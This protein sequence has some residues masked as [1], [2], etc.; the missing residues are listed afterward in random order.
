MVVILDSC[1]LSSPELQNNL[2]VSTDI[3]DFAISL[4]HIHF[5]FLLIVKPRAKFFGL[6]S[7]KVLDYARNCCRRLNV[8]YNTFRDKSQ[9]VKSQMVSFINSQPT[10]RLSVPRISG[11][12]LN[13]ACDNSTLHLLGRMNKVKFIRANTLILKNLIAS[14]SKIYTV[15]AQGGTGPL[16]FS[17]QDETFVTLK[18]PGPNSADVLQFVCFVADSS[19]TKPNQIFQ[20]F[21]IS[22]IDINDN[23]PIFEDYTIEIEENF[24]PPDKLLFTL[25]A[26]DNEDKNDAKLY[27]SIF[28]GKTEVT[29]TGPI[30]KLY[31]KE[32][33]DFEQNVMYRL[34]VTAFDNNRNSPSLNATAT[35][36]INVKD[37]DDEG[38]VFTKQPSFTKLDE[39]TAVGTFVFK[40]KAEDGDRNVKDPITYIITNGSYEISIFDRI[41]NQ[42]GLFRIDASTGE[43]FVAKTFDRETMSNAEIILEITAKE[44]NKGAGRTKSIDCTILIQDVNDEAPTFE[45]DEYVGTITENSF[46][47]TAVQLAGYNNI[48]VSD[49][50]Q[51]QNAAFEVTVITHTDLFHLMP[52]DGIN[53]AYLSLRL[54]NS[55]LLDFETLGSQNPLIVKMMAEDKKNNALKGHATVKVTILDDNDLSPKFEQSRYEESVLED[56]ATNSIVLMVKAK[57]GDT[58]WFGTSGIR[59]S[60]DG[61]VPF[62]IDP[63]SGKIAV[64]SSLDREKTQSYLF[65]VIARDNNGT[66]NSGRAE[67]NILILDVND[68]EP[69]FTQTRYKAALQENEKQFQTPLY[70]KAEDRD[71]GNNALVSYDIKDVTS[72]AIG[73]LN[74]DYFNLIPGLDNDVELIIADS[75]KMDY[76]KLCK[77][78]PKTCSLTVTIEATDKGTPVLK[79]DATVEV[80]LIDVNDEIPMFTTCEDRAELLETDT[81]GKTVTSVSATDKDVTDI[82]R[83][84]KYQFTGVGTEAFDID[85]KTGIITLGPRA[86]LDLGSKTNLFELSVLA[87]DGIYR[88]N[89][90]VCKISVTIKDV[91]NKPPYFTENSY[92][93]T[94]LEDAAV[95]Q[96]LAIS[97]AITASDPDLDHELAFSFGNVIA[98]APDQREYTDKNYIESLF[99]IDPISGSITVASKLDRETVEKLSVT[100]VVTDKKTKIGTKTATA[101]L[102]I[103]IGDVNDNAPVF[104]EKDYKGVVTEK[105]PIGTRIEPIVTAYDI[106]RQ[107]K[108]TFSLSGNEKR[109]NIS[110]DGLLMVISD[111]I[112]RETDSYFDVTVVATDDGQPPRSSSVN[113]RITVLDINDNYPV[114]NPVNYEESISEGM[115]VDSFVLQVTATDKDEGAFGTISYEI[116][117]TGGRGNFKINSATGEIFVASKLDRDIGPDILK[118]G[119]LARDNVNNPYQSLT[120]TASVTIILLDENDN[121]PVITPITTTIEVSEYLVS[122]PYEL[123]TISGIDN[124]AGQNGEIV[125]SLADTNSD[126]IKEFF[127]IT[128]IPGEGKTAKLIVQ[129]FLLNKAVG[130]FEIAV[131]AEDKGSPPQK[132]KQDETIKVRVLDYNNNWP[133]IHYPNE[134]TRKIGVKEDKDI[135][136][137]VFKIDATDDDVAEN[138]KRLDFKIKLPF[139]KV[140]TVDDQG[141]VTLLKKLNRAVTRYY[142]LEFEVC[143]RGAPDPKCKSGSCDIVVQ[144]THDKEPYFQ[145]ETQ[146]LEFNEET[147]P[148]SEIK[149]ILESIDDDN[150]VTNI[151][152]EF[153]KDEAI[154]SICYFIVGGS[155]ARLFQLDRTDRKLK[156]TSTL[157]YEKQNEYVL[158][159]VTTNKCNEEPKILLDFENLSKNYLNLTIEV[160]D[161]NDN[162]PKFTKKVFGGGIIDTSAT[163]EHVLQLE[164]IDVD[165]GEN[166]RVRYYID[167][168]ISVVD[169]EN[170]DANKNKSSWFSLNEETG[171]LKSNYQ[172]SSTMKGYLQFRVKVNNTRELTRSKSNVTYDTAAVKIYILRNDQK[173]IFNV[174]KSVA[175]FRTIREAFLTKLSNL[176]G[177]MAYIN[178]IS[179]YIDPKTSLMVPAWCTVSVHYVDEDNNVIDPTSIEDGLDSDYIALSQLANEFGVKELSRKSATVKSELD[180]V[181]TSIY[182]AGGALLLLITAILSLY[183]NR[184]TKLKRQL[185]ASNLS[186]YSQANRKQTLAP[187]MSTT[188]LHAKAA[189]NPMYD[190][191]ED[192]F[193]ESTDTMSIVS[194]GSLV[195]NENDFEGGRNNGGFAGLLEGIFSAE[196]DKNIEKEKK[197]E[198]L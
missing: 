32:Q 71:E 136:G 26:T 52:S 130:D 104:G 23:P 89:S 96:V 50:D 174:R 1:I 97:P 27:D 4:K 149:M 191:D 25:T 142:K 140:F 110:H 33:F 34:T 192:A 123:T 10:Y 76:E 178:A 183:C 146:K 193:K 15:K 164:A 177:E 112:D 70:L 187:E 121:A 176:T 90:K 9:P 54:K 80:V 129:K 98:Y 21:Y 151:P 29:P 141:S 59:Y 11:H 131:T 84:I 122:V 186:T 41:G 47:N 73:N 155:G 148:G 81:S 85:P 75:A 170:I 114:F 118:F 144:S 13:A 18:N 134:N 51:S 111:D 99:A 197:T 42:E 12:S 156:T 67:V 135:G 194:E 120:S 162:P 6:I 3:P 36:V 44:V 108:V 91:N 171:I 126:Q 14:N 92:E 133:I 55:I 79:N 48:K 5:K 39:N 166:A 101:L 64:A 100:L 93:V 106:D 72:E 95:N 61:N 102:T 8:V 184:V 157:D 143:D 159:I 38:P 82:F 56:V 128:P 22:P 158:Y 16:I 45:S 117:Q 30:Y 77:D 88:E 188:N 172:F 185:K 119:V 86:N 19:T 147:E 127:D 180:P 58:N 195:N 69:K 63:G 167:S 78:I 154:M 181:S 17:L 49:K 175:E 62:K 20:T 43:V 74:N 190:I 107:Q 189:S 40:V 113:Y 2:R 57:D 153:A 138:N 150:N 24:F 160:V 46:A 198:M 173:S 35:V 87:N 66:G 53:E 182:A 137:E 163:T 168:D 68:N 7:D 103:N 65:T 28:M 116:D 31:M 109:V 94:I 105:S 161:V 139:D 132:T 152:D 124:D 115:A 145:Q 125:F 60:I 37:V 196:N 179:P 165:E 83:Q 169:G